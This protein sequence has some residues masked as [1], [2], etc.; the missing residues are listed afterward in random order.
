[1]A[2][3]YSKDAT[4]LVSIIKNMA[5][6][7]KKM[8]L[9]QTYADSLKIIWVVM[10]ALAGAAL[11]ASCFT[12][13][14]SLEQEHKTQQGYHEGARNPVDLEGSAASARVVDE[15]AV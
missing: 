15:I 8:Q 2:G 7:I 9:K 14:Y 3:E 1:M 4:T 13:G 10:C 11:I 6:G 12:K 5:E